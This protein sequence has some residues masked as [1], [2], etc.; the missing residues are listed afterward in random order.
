METLAK[1][2]E[3]LT[4]PEA[5]ERLR[6]HPQTVWRMIYEGR[7]PALQLGGPGTSVR[8]DAGELDHWLFNERRAS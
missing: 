8:I 7:L 2:R 1:T 5:A 4:V 3:L 6:L